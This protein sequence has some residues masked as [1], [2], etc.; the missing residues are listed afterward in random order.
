MP[1]DTWRAEEVS[2]SVK[3]SQVELSEDIPAAPT[4]GAPVVGS[5]EYAKVKRWHVNRVFYFLIFSSVACLATV[6]FAPTPVVQGA[7]LV[8]WGGS[9]G[10][11]RFLLAGAYR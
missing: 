1:G 4:L 5:E 11:A 10:L 9:V 7:A 3:Y 6:V 8:V 2:I